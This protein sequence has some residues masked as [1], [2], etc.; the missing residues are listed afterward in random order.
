MTPCPQTQFLITLVSSLF[1]PADMR[2]CNSWN[3][4]TWTYTGFKAHSNGSFLYSGNSRTSYELLEPQKLEKMIFQ[5]LNIKFA[6]K[7]I[8]VTLKITWA[9]GEGTGFPIQGSCV[10]NHRVAPW[11][12]Q[13]F[14]LPRSI[15]WVRVS[16]SLVV[17]S[18]LSPWSGS[19]LEAVEP[20]P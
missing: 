9:S 17:K 11:L 14:I 19:S 5:Q 8:R 3:E 4:V 7:S 6:L 20:H 1:K 13:P 10:Q 2:S 18:K 16:G 12:T 15:K